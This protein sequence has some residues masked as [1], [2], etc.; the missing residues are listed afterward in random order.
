MLPRERL[1]DAD[2]IPVLSTEGV[3][4]D[5]GG[6][7][8]RGGVALWAMQGTC[9]FLRLATTMVL[10]RCLTPEQFGLVAVVTAF[11]GLFGLLR[12][13][14]LPLAAL[15]RAELDQEQASSLFWI[16]A[17]LG[18]VTA[19]AVAGS[20]PVLAAFY[21]DA[22]LAP[23][24][25]ALSAGALLE[26]VTLQHQA[27]MRRRMRFAPLA[28]IEVLGASVAAAAAIGAA[29]VLDAGQWALVVQMLCRAAASTVGVWL[30]S[31]WRPS[32]V[33]QLSRISPMLSFGARLTASGFINN[34]FHQLNDLLVGRFAG[35]AGLGLFSRASALQVFPK[36][37]FSSS[38]D[39]IAIAGLS[40][41]QDQPE[42]YRRYYARALLPPVLLGMPCVAFMFV[43]A[44]DLAAIVLGEQWGEVVP[45]FRLLTP[46]AFL[47]TFNLATAWVVVSSDLTRRHL[48]W[49]LVSTSVR[50]A[51]V[52]LG[53]RFGLLGMAAGLSAASLLLRPLGIA[54]CLRGSPLRPA[55][56]YTVLWRPVLAALTSAGALAAIERMVPL[57]GPPLLS[58]LAAALLYAPLYGA[59]WLVLPGGPGLLREQLA[60]LHHLRPSAKQPVT[61]E[62]EPEPP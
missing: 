5:L 4:E 61:H 49:S 53:A 24:A 44:E 40:R 7:S 42:R 10:A 25:V 20:A 45:V 29:T 54:Y 38:L 2:M 9:G 48:R 13:M 6:R 47:A 55:D 11:A 1:E 27:V 59:A 16:N 28:G 37:V 12:T 18:V 22:R 15:Q 57:P 58:L 26:G 35:A 56:V 30:A 36:G 31:G 32:L 43:A 8:V 60:L 34:G 52:L 19:L 41:I 23:I 3:E 14:G 50:L 17:A 62:L 51:A 46:V 33:L 39:L 21:D